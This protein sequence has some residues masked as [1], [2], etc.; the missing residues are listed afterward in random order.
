MKPVCHWKLCIRSSSS[1]LNRSKSL[2]LSVNLRVCI[3]FCADGGIIAGAIIAAVVVCVLIAALL[4]YV[5]RVKGYKVGGM[6]M[7]TQRANVNTVSSELVQMWL[8]PNVFRFSNAGSD[9]VLSFILQPA[10]SN[11]NFPSESFT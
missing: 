2:D 1:D 6:R 11:P 9:C 4:Y 3:C 8:A 10:F 5:F 7:Q